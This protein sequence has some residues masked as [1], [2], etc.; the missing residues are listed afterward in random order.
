MAELTPEQLAA[1][2]AAK[3]EEQKAAEIKAQSKT[4]ALRELSKELGINAFE[5]N[6]L[7][8][9]FDEFKTWQESQK[10]EQQKL[11]EALESYKAKEAEWQS[12]TQT[13][14]SKLK[15]MEL[16]ISTDSLEDALKLAGGDPEKLP[17]VIKKYPIFKAKEGIKIGIQGNQGT[18]PTGNTEVEEYMKSN[19]IYAKYLKK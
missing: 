6:E 17:D 2:E 9:K 10:S 12:Q 18:P 16:G 19:P 13:Y 5:P 3:L 11:Q 14:A 7:K 8:A 1:Q 15:A 4:E